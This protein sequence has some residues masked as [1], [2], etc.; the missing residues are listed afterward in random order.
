MSSASVSH[1]LFL[2]GYQ[3]YGI[4]GPPYHNMTSSDYSSVVTPATTLFSYTCN[5]PVFKRSHIQRFQKDLNLGLGMVGTLS[6]QVQ[7]SPLLNYKVI[8]LKDGVLYNTS[9]H[10]LHTLSGQ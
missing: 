7:L 2:Q 4:E 8:C 6:N 3:S 9:L 1:F 5:N 10:L